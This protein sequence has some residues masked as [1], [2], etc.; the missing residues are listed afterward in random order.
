MKPRFLVFFAKTEPILANT[1]HTTPRIILPKLRQTL[2][3]LFYH[4]SNW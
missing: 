2:K 3:I 4:L 1:G